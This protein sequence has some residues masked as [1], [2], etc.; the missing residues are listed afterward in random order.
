MPRARLSELHSTIPGAEGTLAACQAIHDKEEKNGN[1]Y[2]YQKQ[3][4]KPEKGNGK[5]CHGYTS[6]TV[7]LFAASGG[8]DAPNFQHYTT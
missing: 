6:V 2:T 5:K 1:S 7:P 3:S 4:K 8:H